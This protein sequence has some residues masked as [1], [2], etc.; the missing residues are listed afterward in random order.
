MRK[1]HPVSNHEV[2]MREDS[3]LVSTTDLKGIITEVNPDFVS[4]SGFSEQELLGKNHNLVRHPDMPEAA[5]KDLWDTVK[6]GR[7]WIGLVKNRCKNGDHYWV[8]ANV[9]PVLEHG[10]VTGYISVRHKPERKEL[11]AANKLYNEINRGKAS[12]NPTLFKRIGG[13]WSN[14]SIAQRFFA[15]L[16]VIGGMI[17]N[18]GY[19]LHTQIVTG[20][21]VESL[22]HTL[23]YELGGSFAAL[24]VGSSLFVWRV[25]LPG[26]RNVKDAL[27]Q[28]TEGDFHSDIDIDR[29]D[30]LGDLLR[31]S[32]VLQIRQGY[33]INDSRQQLNRAARIQSA[34]D[35]TTANVMM[36]DQN[37]NIIYINDTLQKM[38][39]KNESNFKKK[40]PNFNA[41]GLIG[42]C[43]DVFHKDPSHQR[44][45]LDNLTTTFE[46][47]DMNLGGTWVKIIVNPVF[48]AQG[49][50]IA[51]VT[52]WLDRTQ[53]VA[54]EQMIEHDVKGLVEAA[55]RGELSSRI[56]IGE[57]SGQIGELSQS[58][59]ELLAVTEQ[60][61][62][63]I[64]QGLQALER[65]DLTYRISN[66]YQGM[67]D[68]AKQANNN[69]AAQMASVMG[70]VRVTAEEVGLGADEI[71]EG[72]NTLSARTQEQAAALEE[73]AA[74]IEEI[75]GTVQ[76]T[77]D[78]SRQANLLA[79]GAREQ[80]EKGGEIATQTVEAMAEINTNSKKI[81]DII[82]VIDEIAFQTN[83]LAL[84]AA[85]E[86]ARAGEQGRGF[87]V[88]AGEV[89]TLAQRSAGAAKEI[90]SLIN[91]SVESVASGSRLV[92]ESG[93][94]LQSIIG[95]VSQVGDIIAEIASASTEQTLGV[96]QINQ[97]IAQLDTNT[98][99]NTAM[100]EESAAASQRLNDQAGE[101]RQQ[102]ERFQL[103]A[104][105][106][107]AMGDGDKKVKKKVR[108]VAKKRAKQQVREIVA[109]QSAVQAMEAEHDD[110]W[111][112]F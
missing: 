65:G 62:D 73:T 46:S 92:N 41:Q 71:A 61:I 89:R 70:H 14:R 29:G 43:I 26:I 39:D 31:V 2:E 60:G 47:P 74:S 97:A 108:K 94:A 81:A 68:A 36:A 19:D 16:A 77:A 63:D 8:K 11:E 72:N 64:I 78:N 25:I 4:I 56:E 38:L 88:V 96:E 98:Q 112:E 54:L 111:Q 109:S 45:I 84:N 42:T 33:M 100:V 110:V 107:V 3:I 21:S 66:D 80:A 18:V 104:S 6:A 99:Q 1:N 22:T 28:I 83:L 90:K 35:S 86:A 82:G 103:D 5:F 75:T 48:D 53:D 102:I 76:Q 51:T 44:R 32:K 52:E 37:H 69:A 85:V 17:A 101:L 105:A 20:A 7:P 59:N 30:E 106:T 93:E 23:I 95:A 27:I 55:K 12:L 40:L 57:A 79:T 91:Q 34:L 50:R 67:F 24:L 10:Q 49:N 58:L 13:L 87:A 15:G 9:A